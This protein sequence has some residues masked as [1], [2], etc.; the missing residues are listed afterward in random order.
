MKIKLGGYCS[1]PERVDGGS[2]CMVAVKLER[3]SWIL[4]IFESRGNGIC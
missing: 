2:D 4:N 3:R 1:N